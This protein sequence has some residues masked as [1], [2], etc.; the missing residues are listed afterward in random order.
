MVLIAQLLCNALTQ[1]A[2]GG[3][4]GMG[5]GWNCHR[6]MHAAGIGAD[7]LTSFKYLVRGSGQTEV[8]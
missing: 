4:F 1:F 8:G 7:Q 6:R 5:A 3:E 2:D